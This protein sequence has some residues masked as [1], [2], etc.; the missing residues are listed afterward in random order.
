MTEQRRREEE[1]VNAQYVC[2]YLVDTTHKLRSSKRDEREVDMVHAGGRN[3]TSQVPDLEEK[4]E[5]ANGPGHTGM[6]FPPDSA[7]SAELETG[8]SAEFD[9]P[10]TRD[11]SSVSEWKEDEEEEDGVEDDDERRRED[12]VA[13]KASRSALK[14]S[15][16]RSMS[17]PASSDTLLQHS[18][19]RSLVR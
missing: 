5:K 2:K 13:V 1:L 12:D 11:T 7:A 6:F 19:I 17:Y 9:A 16:P 10:G 8:G 18:S 4:E 14:I 15:N 3:W